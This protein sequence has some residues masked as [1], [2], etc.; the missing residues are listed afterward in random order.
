VG[1]S[2]VIPIIAGELALP[3]WQTLFL[4]DFDRPRERRAVVCTIFA[5]GRAGGG[6]SQSSS[7]TDT[8]TS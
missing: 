5:H 1:P 4:C 8:G 2:E 3:A 6:L 7:A